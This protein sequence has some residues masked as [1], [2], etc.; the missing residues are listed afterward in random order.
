MAVKK[1]L[2]EQY[3]TLDPVA[4]LAE[5]R[6]IQEELGNRIDRR[7]GDARGQQRAGKSTA[8]QP[9]QSSTRTQSLAKTLGMMVKAEDPRATHR[10]LIRRG[11]R[12]GSH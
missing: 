11:A 6:A 3:R 9:G 8:P 4:L 5:I 2:R 7:A 12:S 10:R 1:R